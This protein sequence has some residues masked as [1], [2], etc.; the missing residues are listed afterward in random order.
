MPVGSRCV[1]LACL[2]G[3]E[4]EGLRGRI[5]DVSCEPRLLCTHSFRKLT[6]HR[7]PDTAVLA[8]LKAT[9]RHPQRILPQHSTLTAC[10]KPNVADNAKVSRSPFLEGVGWWANGV[11]EECQFRMPSFGADISLSVR[12]SMQR[13]RHLWLRVKDISHIYPLLRGLPHQEKHHSLQ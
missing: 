7:R 1:S 11:W 3:D 4:C 13:K 2:P 6:T 12:C 9:L 10:S 5:C 8:E